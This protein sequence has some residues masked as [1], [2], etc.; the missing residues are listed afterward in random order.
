M[1]S[2]PVVKRELQEALFQRLNTYD[3]KFLFINQI[4][5]KKNQ[6]QES[7]VKENSLLKKGIQI[8]NKKVTDMKEEVV[9]NQH[10][11]MQNQAMMRH[12]EMT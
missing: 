10:L 2:D 1:P 4:D 8:C 9:Q 6:N 7:L 3:G 5:L 11:K 12:A